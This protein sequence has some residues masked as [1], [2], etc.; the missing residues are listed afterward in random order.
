MHLL[1]SRSKWC[2]RCKIYLLPGQKV[3]APTTQF[4][5]SLHDGAFGVTNFR[6]ATCIIIHR[7]HS[8]WKS[9]SLLFDAH[10]CNVCFACN[11]DA[12]ML[13]LLLGEKGYNQG[14]LYNTNLFCTYSKEFRHQT[15]R[16]QLFEHVA[17]GA[18]HYLVQVP[19]TPN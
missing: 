17:L 7:T 18:L 1:S 19:N 5:H 4:S 14:V 6:I 11:P 15:H 12:Y 8:Q 3:G 2:K 10:L 9:L 13:T 16:S